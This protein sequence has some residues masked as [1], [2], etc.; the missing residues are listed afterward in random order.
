MHTSAHTRLAVALAAAILT[1]TCGTAAAQADTQ[2]TSYSQS[3]TTVNATSGSQAAITFTLH[4]VNLPAGTGTTSTTGPNLTLGVATTSDGSPLT[5]YTE[6]APP[7]VYE[8]GG[9]SFTLGL[10]LKSGTVADGVWTAT[11]S[12]A[13]IGGSYY[14]EPTPGWAGVYTPILVY[15]AGSTI[16]ASSL[17]A[18]GAAPLVASVT[19]AP[20]PILATA[21]SII[22][23]QGF[24]ASPAFGLAGKISWT[25]SGAQPIALT[26]DSLSG[27]GCNGELWEH[28][29]SSFIIDEPPFGSCTVQFHTWNSAGRSPEVKVKG[30]F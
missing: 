27:T 1:A 21:S 28:S 19:Q 23:W 8:T 5:G 10:A 25:N 11:T 18:V 3:A 17:E 24:G 30:T 15:G 9:L 29:S 4:I 7:T 20:S 6:P 12:E 26:V 13:T 16:T 22:E 14:E 2:V